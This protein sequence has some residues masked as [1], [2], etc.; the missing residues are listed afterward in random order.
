MADQPAGI[1]TAACKKCIEDTKKQVFNDTGQTI[2]DAEA[3]KQCA[4]CKE[5]PK[6]KQGVV[7][8]AASQMVNKL[9][10]GSAA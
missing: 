7:A 1:D 2:T 8:E 5:P 4:S 3:R 10:G 6:P 9:P